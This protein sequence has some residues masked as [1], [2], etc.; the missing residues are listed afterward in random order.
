MHGA[1]SPGDPPSLGWLANGHN[2]I[3]IEPLHGKPVQGLVG[4]EG[5]D[6]RSEEPTPKS[7]GPFATPSPQPGFPGPAAP[8][9]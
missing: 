8:S 7:K 6:K 9:S 5:K 2:L 3:L 4:T 1:V